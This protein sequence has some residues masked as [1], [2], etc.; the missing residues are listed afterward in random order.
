MTDHDH[1]SLP[2]RTDNDWKS[3]PERLSR[4]RLR[5][6]T[7]SG[8]SQPRCPPLGRRNGTGRFPSLRMP[9][10]VPSVYGTVFGKRQC[11][12]A[13]ISV[14]RLDCPTDSGDSS[15]LALANV[16]RPRA[17][18]ELQHLIENRITASLSYN[19]PFADNNNW[20]TTFACGQKMNRQ[21]LGR[22]AARKR[23]GPTGH[24]HGPWSGRMGEPRRAIWSDRH[25]PRPDQVLARLHLR[26][27]SGRACEVRHRQ[28][29]EPLHRAEGVGCCLL[30]RPE[31]RS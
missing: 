27:L 3:P 17:L 7:R 19:K 18:D 30:F 9:G 11:F 22:V 31:P 8:L 15:F 12:F 6:G 4:D 26:F 28:A 25:R 21:Y 13:L 24:A 23:C 16:R 29:G 2:S 5:T 1:L 10:I 14:A 20:A